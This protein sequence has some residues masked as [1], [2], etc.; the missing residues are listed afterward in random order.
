[1]WQDHLNEKNKECLKK[2]KEDSL[3]TGD[4]VHGEIIPTLVGPR[5]SQ[6]DISC[7]RCGKLIV[8]RRGTA[9]SPKM[10]YTFLT[11]EDE[12][13]AFPEMRKVLITLTDGATLRIM[14]C[15]NCVLPILSHEDDDRLMFVVVMGHCIFFTQ[16]QKDDAFIKKQIKELERFRVEKG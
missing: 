9:F 15:E 7:M 13:K 5:P 12:L 4:Y 14:V 8:D 3:Y 11:E 6:T 1:M 10:V 2:S 16:C